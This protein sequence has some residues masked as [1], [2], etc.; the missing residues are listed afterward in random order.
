VNQL[1]LTSV[2]L[3]LEAG[4]AFLK[5]AQFLLVPLLRFESERTE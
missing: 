1:N 3:L 5:K 4:N 2:V